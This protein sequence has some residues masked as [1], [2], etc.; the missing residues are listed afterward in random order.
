MGGCMRVKVDV[1]VFLGWGWI[2]ARLCGCQLALMALKVVIC[3][4]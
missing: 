1:C 2:Y 3:G 4:F